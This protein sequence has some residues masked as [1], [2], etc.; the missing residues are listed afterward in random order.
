MLFFQVES[1]IQ[2]ACEGFK[3]ELLNF[4]NLSLN[5]SKI[6]E[7]CQNLIRS[8]KA[9]DTKQQKPTDRQTDKQISTRKQLQNHTYMLIDRQT[10]HQQI[11]MFD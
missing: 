5:S 3:L 11:R 9:T 8:L 10:T 6:L 7:F 1:E 2:Q 4:N